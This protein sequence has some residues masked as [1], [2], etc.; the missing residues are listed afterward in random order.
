[1]RS[2][3]EAHALTVVTPTTAYRFCQTVGPELWHFKKIDIQKM[4]DSAILR[5]TLF[6]IA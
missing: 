3:D 6:Y 5:I 2:D 1:M 4:A